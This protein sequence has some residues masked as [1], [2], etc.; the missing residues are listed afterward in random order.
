MPKAQRRY[1]KNKHARAPVDDDDDDAPKGKRGGGGSASDDG[2]ADYNKAVTDLR[3]FMQTQS[4]GVGIVAKY[5]QE[6]TGKRI[7]L[8]YVDDT[9]PEWKE[10]LENWVIISRAKDTDDNVISTVAMALPQLAPGTTKAR[11]P[12]KR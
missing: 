7:S 8:K 10:S 5:L 3:S 9:P 6:K 4:H 1:D 11:H 2:S 12:A